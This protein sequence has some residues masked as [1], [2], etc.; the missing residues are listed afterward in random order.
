MFVVRTDIKS[1]LKNV[2][3]LLVNLGIFTEKQ[4]NFNYGKIWP[5]GAKDVM[6]TLNKLG[7]RAIGYK[8]GRGGKFKKPRGLKMELVELNGRRKMDFLSYFKGEFSFRDTAVIG[9][10]SDDADLVRHAIFSVTTPG[11]PLELKMNTDYVS[12]FRGLKAL[13]EIGNLIVHAKGKDR[14]N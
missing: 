10:E 6:D 11:A 4:D 14:E 1:K 5:H 7:V 3:V 13:E 12:N 8:T 2:K 9:Y